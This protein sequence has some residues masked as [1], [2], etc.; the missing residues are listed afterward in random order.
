MILITQHTLIFA[1]IAILMTASA[2]LYLSRPWLQRTP[3]GGVDRGSFTVKVYRDQLAELETDMNEQRLTEEQYNQA[4]Q[5]LERSMMEDLGRPGP[6]VPLPEPEDKT[7]SAGLWALILIGISLPVLALIL[8]GV[9]H[10][11]IQAMAP[12][13]PVAS[14]QREPPSSTGNPNFSIEEMVSRLAARMEADPSDATGWTMLGRSYTVLKRYP[15]SRDAYGK[16]YELRAAAGLTQ[17]DSTLLSDYAEAIGNANDNHFGPQAMQILTRALELDANNQKA[18]W[19]AGMGAFQ[20][21]QYRMAILHWERLYQLIP[22]GSEI[23]NNLQGAIEE[24]KIRN[25]DLQ[26]VPEE[27]ETEPAN[28]PATGSDKSA[29]RPPEPEP[30]ATR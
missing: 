8:Y 4:R 30:A 1:L 22:K 28:P 24:A 7:R 14:E 10:I 20:A 11:S 19:L 27:N 21:K 17:D 5:E 15:E 13:A 9:L 26:I 2:V 6:S 29:A 18:L 25:G 16:A 3:R 23:S 12:P